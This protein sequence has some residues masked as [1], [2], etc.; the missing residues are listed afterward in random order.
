MTDAA[1]AQATLEIDRSE[2]EFLDDH[3]ASCPPAVRELHRRYLDTAIPREEAAEREGLRLGRLLRALNETAPLS[4][5]LSYACARWQFVVRSM[6]ALC[7]DFHG[8]RFGAFGAP[9][10]LRVYLTEEAGLP[11][12][13]F[14]LADWNF[15]DG[16][17]PFFVGYAYGSVHDGT[18]FLSGL[19]SDMA[20]RYT[21][22]F[23][24]QDGETEVREGE[25]VVLRSTDDLQTLYGGYVPLFRKAFQR[26]SIPALMGGVVA[27]ARSRGLDAVALHR[28]PLTAEESRPGNIV[29]RVYEGVPAKVPGTRLE[30]RTDRASYR[31]HR[32]EL[33][34]VAEYVAATK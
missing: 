9:I 26:K 3:F 34:D 30:V 10:T 19:Q 7:D 28:F 16:G 8:S 5:G 22:L 25:E 13:M 33:A 31:Y 18:M 6:D 4:G 12:E 2:T 27:V 1:C 23:L 14:R 15:M 17:Q 11:A 29:H 21:Y 32:M 24:A 20:Q